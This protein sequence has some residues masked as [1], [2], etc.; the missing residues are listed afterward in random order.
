M[1]GA[2]NWLAGQ[3][4]VINIPPRQPSPDTLLLS[5]V[6]RKLMFPG[7]VLFVPLLVAG[8]GVYVYLT[9]RG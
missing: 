1:A 2:V 6:Q 8:L 9:H 7:F 3:D 5:D 4:K